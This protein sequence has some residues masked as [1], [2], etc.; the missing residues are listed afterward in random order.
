MAN[1][2]QQEFTQAVGLLADELGLQRLRDRFVKL[3]GLVTRRR[4]TSVQALSDQLYL[5]T[6]GLRRQVPATL[7][8]HSIWN[9]LVTSKIGEEGEKRLEDTARKINDCLGDRDEIVADKEAQLEDAL[10]QYEQQLV[11]VVGPERARL[12]MLLK[13]VSAVATK[14]RTMPP[15]PPAPPAAE[16]PSAPPA[17]EDAGAD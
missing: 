6:S 16:D 11:A 7:A 10:R 9:E 2:T 5:L 13:A 17:S 1:L 12:D 4:A 14:L 3:N 15:T 8:F